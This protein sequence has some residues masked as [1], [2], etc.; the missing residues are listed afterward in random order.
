MRKKVRCQALCSLF[1]RVLCLWQI[2]E[3]F[4]VG[5]VLPGSQDGSPLSLFSLLHPVRELYFLMNSV[6]FSVWVQ[7]GV[8]TSLRPVAF[9][10]ISPRML[11]FWSWTEP[12]PELEASLAIS[13]A[14]S[15]S[16]P[17]KYNVVMP[18]VRLTISHQ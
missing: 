2:R 10:L 12:C 1:L 18:S 3:R 14:S 4:L 15:E 6:R 5:P 16:S 8:P 17:T 9:P 13:G 7:F 11:P